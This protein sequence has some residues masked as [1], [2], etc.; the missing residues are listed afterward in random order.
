MNNLTFESGQYYTLSLIFSGEHKIIIPDL[1]RDYCWGNN[2]WNEL[3]K[4]DSELVSGFIDKLFTLFREKPNDK[5]TM[6]L[7]YGYESP[8]HHIQL[9]DGQQR[10]TT[11]FLL[12]GMINKKTENNKFQQF[13]ISNNE[14][15]HDDREPYLQYAIR[16]ST[17]Y[18][19]S[20]LVCEFFLKKMTIQDI[21]K[22][23]W[24]F[25]EYE[26]DASI[27][28]MLAAIKLIDSKL[29]EKYQSVNIFDFGDYILNNLQMIYYDMGN[30]TRGEETFVIINTTGEPLTAT[31]NLKPVL[32]GNL[33]NKEIKFPNGKDEPDKETE[34]QYYSR[35]WEDREEWF[36]Q[37]RQGG[38]NKKNK[39][40]DNG[41]R[42]FFR[43]ISI[44]I[45]EKDSKA[46]KIELDQI[47]ETTNFKFVG[48]N[49][50]LKKIH[51]YFKIV[52]F[53]F[54][55]NG[56]FKNNLDWL[57]PDESDK[58]INTQII[59]FRLLPVI[60]Y[61]YRFGDVTDARKILRVKTFFKNL[62]R[63]E[64]ISK[65]AGDLLFDAIKIIKEMPNDDIA[66]VLE[67]K[68]VS[69]QILR[70][71]EKI[72]FELYINTLYNRIELEA[73]FWEAEEH[74][75]WNGEILTLINW[76]YVDG[77]FI[78]D[79][80]DEIKNMFNIL[81]F[82][83]CKNNELDLV[84]RALLTMNL[85]QYPKHFR[86]YTNWSFCWEASDWKALIEENTNE[87]G[88]FLNELN[89]TE[90]SFQLNQM[91]ANNPVD[92]KFDEFV[93]I[94]ELLAYC[95]QKNIQWAG[96]KLGWILVKNEKTSGEHAN[97]NTFRLFLELKD[98]IFWMEEWGVL[99]FYP[100]NGSCAYL[101]NNSKN[102]TVDIKYSGDN[103]FHIQFFR[104]NNI[105]A[106]VY[107]EQLQIIAKKYSL[108]WIEK[109]ESF[110]SKK[111][112]KNELMVFLN[113]FLNNTENFQTLN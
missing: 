98:K 108:E 21:I 101:D 82:A 85:N 32:L 107:K 24:Y 88:K 55:E 12:L 87:F 67:L 60:E 9:C 42:E 110:S 94:S 22:Q 19:L 90:Y 53:L 72:K 48:E 7:I 70:E 69:I 84:R 11:L 14:L 25:N 73:R 27:Q 83:D 13:L 46:F 58:Y 38:G 92:K 35:K 77:V 30:R 36:W 23:D 49:L 18:F 81:F 40:A 95:N 16:E 39:I 15:N 61:V 4:K 64:N 71:E 51:E 106:N 45:S 31:E 17:L 100:Y 41:V 37:K 113:L 109:D 86:G 56:L 47:R 75:I 76:S 91:I 89:L 93:K 62:S 28:S 96:D 79:R 52:Q 54:N 103:L 29:N 97:L 3:G 8:R 111:F 74:K 6:G 1:Q 59:W 20:D 112:K 10:I 44:L 50:D 5:L 99:K 57:S 2:V 105:K 34:L 33:D 102:V 78:L 65:N 43:W 66:S 80:F 63:I 104:K 26:L 68:N